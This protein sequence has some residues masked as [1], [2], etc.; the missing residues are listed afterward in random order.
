[1][2]STIGPTFLRTRPT[3]QSVLRLRCGSLQASRAN[4]HDPIDKSVTGT[5]RSANRSFLHPSGGKGGCVGPKSIKPGIFGSA[6]RHDYESGMTQRR[7]G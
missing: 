5:L 3:D 6:R 1:M 4:R 2:P 7:D